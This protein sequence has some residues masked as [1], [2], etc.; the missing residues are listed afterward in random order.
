MQ[1]TMKEL[2][3]SVGGLSDPSKMP[4]YAYG[5][6]AKDCMVGS[7][8][9]DIPKS[10]CSKCY[11]RKGMYSFPVVRIAQERRLKIVLTN[12]PRWQARMTKLLLRKYRKSAKK[13]PFFRWH[14]SGDIQSVEHLTAI[15]KIA[16]MVRWVNFWLPTKEYGIIREWLRENG[17]FPSNLLVRVS[18]PMLGESRVSIPG[19]LSSTV[20]ANEGFSCEAYKRGGKCG[21]CRACW[22]PEILS[23]DY[24]L[25]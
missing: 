22:D 18:N 9:R 7:I 15:A 12:L 23:V 16:K 2:E 20:G 25:H 13:D 24:P 8:L 10:V 17:S 4:G 3:E 19:T 11:A 6:P 14:D 1:E 5:T 21:P